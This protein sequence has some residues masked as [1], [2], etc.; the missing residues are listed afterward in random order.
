MSV[1][2]LTMIQALAYSTN[3][4]IRKFQKVC[5]PVASIKRNSWFSY[6]ILTFAAFYKYAVKICATFVFSSGSQ[7]TPIDPGKVIHDKRPPKL[8]LQ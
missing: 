3:L 2:W 7:S 5:C 6:I 8:W 1:I 4:S